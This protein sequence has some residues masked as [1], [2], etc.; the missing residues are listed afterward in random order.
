MTK[1]LRSSTGKEA[2]TYIMGKAVMRRFG[3][4]LKTTVRRTKDILFLCKLIMNSTHSKLIKTKTRKNRSEMCGWEVVIER[5]REF[6]ND[7][8]VHLG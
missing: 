2:H 1:T 5:K 6:G 4:M 8:M 3:V 7:P